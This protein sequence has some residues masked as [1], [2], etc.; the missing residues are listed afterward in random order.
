VKIKKADKA[1]ILTVRKAKKA[2][3]YIA[4]IC[5]IDLYVRNPCDETNKP[6]ILYFTLLFGV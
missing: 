5:L 6:F 4:L 2:E 3:S 1:E